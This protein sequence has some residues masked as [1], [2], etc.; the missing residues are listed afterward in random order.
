MSW[1][2]AVYPTINS[3]P[4]ILPAKMFITAK[5]NTFTVRYKDLVAKVGFD[6]FHNLYRTGLNVFRQ[7]AYM[8]TKL[9]E[10]TALTDSPGCSVVAKRTRHEFDTVAQKY[11]QLLES[12]KNCGT[13]VKWFDEADLTAHRACFNNGVCLVCGE[14]PKITKSNFDRHTNKHPLLYN[15]IVVKKFQKEHPGEPVCVTLLD[16]DEEKAGALNCVF[17]SQPFTSDCAFLVT[18]RKQKRKI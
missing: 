17:F 3:A 11:E 1:Q 2:K 8:N 12:Y 5:V 16:Y 10:I 4:H 6:I 18:V 15:L 14:V 7:G 13:K 9:I